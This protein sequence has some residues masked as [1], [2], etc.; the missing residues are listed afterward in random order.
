[1]TY[2]T[3]QTSTSTPHAGTYRHKEFLSS[4]RP[5]LRLEAGQT[6]C[7]RLKD[8]SPI[9]WDFF[10]YNMPILEQFITVKWSFTLTL[11]FFKYIHGKRIMRK[12]IKTILICDSNR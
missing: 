6:V 4:L 5:L 7:R 11:P 8:A 1:M 12:E 3:A 2:A 9:E 10:I